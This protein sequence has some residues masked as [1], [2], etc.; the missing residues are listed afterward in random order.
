MKLLNGSVIKKTPVVL[1]AENNILV[2]TV[3]VIKSHNQTQ[4]INFL[5]KITPTDDQT[6]KIIT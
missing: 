5:I 3:V 2:D 1:M 6:L 4:H